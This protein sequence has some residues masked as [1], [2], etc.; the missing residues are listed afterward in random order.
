M[1][2]YLLPLLIGYTGGKMV[3]GVRGG[4]L[5]AIATMG[6]IVAAL[7]SALIALVPVIGPAI[8]SFLAPLMMLYGLVDGFLTDFK[9]SKPKLAEDI[10]EAT[11][12]AAA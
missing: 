3:Y 8:V 11:A 2:N 10:R 9:S 7:L 5:G 1:I 6:V 4:V 12:F